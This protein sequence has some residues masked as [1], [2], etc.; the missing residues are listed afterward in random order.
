MLIPLTT[1]IVFLI[2]LFVSLIYFYNQNIKC[3][4]MLKYFL[5]GLFFSILILMLYFLTSDSLFNINLG[6]IFLFIMFFSGFIDGFF[7]ILPGASG[8]MTV[9]ILG[10]Y[11]VYTFM[12]SNICAYYLI[13]LILYYVGDL[14]GLVLGSRFNLYFYTTKKLPYLNT[15]YGLLIGS[16]IVLFLAF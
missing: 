16:L 11:Y 10:T 8:S 7:T 9:M 1:K 2:F 13:P 3:E 5:L 14:V 4:F 6:F 15:I 12:F